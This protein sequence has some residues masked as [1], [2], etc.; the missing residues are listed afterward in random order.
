MKLQPEVFN[1][2]IE[3]YKKNGYKF[4]VEEK[5]NNKKIC[6]ENQIIRKKKNV[7]VKQV[8]SKKAQSLIGQVK[9]Q[10]NQYILKNNFQIPIVHNYYFATQKNT[11]IYKELEN[12]TQLLHI[13]VKHC[14]W[15]IAYNFGIISKNLYKRY[16]TD[17]DMKLIRNIALACLVSQTKKT[18]YNFDGNNKSEFSV[19]EDISIY[20]L[21][22][23]NI[24]YTAYNLLGYLFLKLQNFAYFYRIDGILIL[25]NT[26]A[27]K[28][29]CEYFENQGFN[30][31]INKCYKLNDTQ[32]YNI[33]KEK[34]VLL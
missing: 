2:Y 28:T 29:V 9:K 1:D 22:Y 25:D 24:R 7:T 12:G 33:D 27:Q 32:F 34:T 5:R 4:A 19:T 16:A 26:K 21:I 30:Y 6:F 13:D 31:E 23:R 17:K 11:D 20:Q 10:A 15:R 18:F 8:R 3:M 14:Y